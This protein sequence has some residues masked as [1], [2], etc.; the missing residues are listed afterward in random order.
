M[1]V[2]FIPISVKM[3]PVKIYKELTDVFV[4]KDL[5]QI[6]T[7]KSVWVREILLMKKDFIVISHINPVKSIDFHVHV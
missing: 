5:H 3:E 4:I 7:E 6:P 1:N 2:C